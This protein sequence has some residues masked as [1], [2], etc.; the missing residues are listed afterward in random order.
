MRGSLRCLLATSP[1][2]RVR[3]TVATR[4]GETGRIVN[5]VAVHGTTRETTLRDN[6][7]RAAIRVGRLPRFTG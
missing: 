5:R 1:R 4:P 7:G 2:A 6:V 3:F